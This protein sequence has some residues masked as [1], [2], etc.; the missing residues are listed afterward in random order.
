MLC[1]KTLGHFWQALEWSYQKNFCIFPNIIFQ[2]ILNPSEKVAKYQVCHFC[3]IWI[4]L[5]NYSTQHGLFQLREVTQLPPIWEVQTLTI[6]FHHAISSQSIRK[7]KIA[8]ENR[9]E[10]QPG[11]IESC[12]PSICPDKIIFVPGKIF[13]SW[14]KQF[15][16]QTKN[17]VQG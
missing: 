9:V 17:F 12:A 7:E 3:Q 16:S 1:S 11:V 5:F 2:K 14:T 8:F 13:L 6:R 4:T 15:L 10:S